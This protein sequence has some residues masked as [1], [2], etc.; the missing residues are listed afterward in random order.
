[1]TN[2][3][4]TLT[5]NDVEPFLEELKHREIADV[6]HQ[7][8]ATGHSDSSL[9]EAITKDFRT[10]IQY[11]V[12]VPKGVNNQ[13]YY[14]GNAWVMNN[15][16]EWHRTYDNK[17]D[18]KDGLHSLDLD[19]T[20]YNEF[21]SSNAGA[22]KK[23]A[24]TETLKVDSGDEETLEKTIR[25]SSNKGAI[26][27]IKRKHDGAP[28]TIYTFMAGDYRGNPTLKY[29]VTVPAVDDTVIDRIRDHIN[30]NDNIRLVRGTISVATSR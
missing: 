7:E 3:L 16:G 11:K 8:S 22:L 6:F 9:F 15:K 27:P 23:T 12:P 24:I 19:P 1:M 5:F 18:L 4:V 21:L 20:A 25:E 29:R 26:H 14:G 2:T 13:R 10:L 28:V 30:S 17:K